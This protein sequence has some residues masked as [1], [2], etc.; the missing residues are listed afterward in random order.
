ME[1]LKSDHYTPLYRIFYFHTTSHTINQNINWSSKYVIITGR[2]WF[3][4]RQNEQNMIVAQN[5]VYSGYFQSQLLGMWAIIS[6]SLILSKSG[7]SIRYNLAFFLEH[8]F[9]NRL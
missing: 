9:A 7:F 2:R 5:K 1:T 8:F 3:H 4:A 6:A